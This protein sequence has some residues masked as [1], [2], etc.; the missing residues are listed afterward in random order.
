MTKPIITMMLA[1][2]FM[3]VAHRSKAVTPHATP[4]DAN[5]QSTVSQQEAVSHFQKTGSGKMEVPLG[6]QQTLTRIAQKKKQTALGKS[7]LEINPSGEVLEMHP[8]FNNAQH[9][10]KA[11]VEE[12]S[13]MRRSAVNHLQINAVGSMIETLD[14]QEDRA[15][16][17]DLGKTEKEQTYTKASYSQLADRKSCDPEDCNSAPNGWTTCNEWL[18]IY[19]SDPGVCFE[20][21]QKRSKCSQSYFNHATNGDGNCGCI[22]RVAV[23]CT[24]ASNQVGQQN[25]RIYSIQA[26][27]TE[28]PTTEAPTADAATR[29]RRKILNSE[30]LP[31]LPTVKSDAHSSPF[32]IWGVMV[33]F[34]IV[35][36]SSQ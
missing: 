6:H 26:P 31:T 13:K 8:L 20:E 15:E 3:L 25:V 21:I 4:P 5:M 35:W 16:H 1:L 9:A 32:S 22:L 19:N 14:V 30:D 11:Q 10:A 18:S 23:D 34:S 12:N 17:A 24:I 28:A 29:R 7:N 27:T 2:A 36:A 33:P